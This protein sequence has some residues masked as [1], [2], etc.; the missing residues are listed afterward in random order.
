MRWLLVILLLVSLSSGTLKSTYQSVNCFVLVAVGDV[1]VEC[2]AI[3]QRTRIRTRFS[4]RSQSVIASLLE[5]DM[6]AVVVRQRRSSS[7]RLCN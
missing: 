3:V 5:R 4:L 7:S 1:V 2:A 6:I